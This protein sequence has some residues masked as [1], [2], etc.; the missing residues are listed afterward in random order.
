MPFI[1]GQSGNPG[2]R[3]KAVADVLDMA[4]GHSVRAIEFLASVMDD[5]SADLRARVAAAK[6]I[7]D[8]GLGRPPQALHHSGE[9][10]GPVQVQHGVDAF[11]EK[12]RQLKARM[13]ATEL[14]PK[15]N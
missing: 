15:R 7:L 9:D 12:I 13:D 10:G 5:T 11:I 2:G 4:R 3:P 6:E 14:S 8:R 1:R